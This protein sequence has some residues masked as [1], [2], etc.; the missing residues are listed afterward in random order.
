MESKR[1]KR[2]FES[3][4]PTQTTYDFA[5]EMFE[6]THVYFFDYIRKKDGSFDA[7][8]NKDDN[9][10]LIND[11]YDNAKKEFEKVKDSIQK[12][13]DKLK[14]E[15]NPSRNTLNKI[16]KN[17][18]RL[19]DLDFV[20]EQF[21]NPEKFEKFRSKH[22]QQL[23]EY[24]LTS[25]LT[26][27]K[28]EALKEAIRESNEYD[29]DGIVK[30]TSDTGESSTH[31]MAYN[32]S[33]LS[34]KFNAKQNAQKT[35]KLLIGSIP[36]MK[37]KDGKYKQVRSNR[38]FTPKTVSFGKTFNTLLTE[39]SGIKG[40]EQAIQKLQSLKKRFPSIEYLFSADGLNLDAITSKNHLSI[41]KGKFN[42][43]IQFAQTFA[44]TMNKYTVGLL[45]EGGER[46]FMDSNLQAE[47]K[48]ITLRWRNN[49]SAISLSKNPN[50]TIQKDNFYNTTLFAYK[51]IKNT[52]EAYEF[53]ESIGIEFTDK[54]RIQELGYVSV[55]KDVADYILKDIQKGNQL[56]VLSPKLGTNHGQNL[57]RLLDIEYE[58]NPDLVVTSHTGPDGQNIYNHTLNSFISNLL[59]NFNKFDNWNDLMSF[60]PH[61]NSETNAWL[62]GSLLLKKNG[63][64]F[65]KDGDK[66]P[67]TKLI[68]HTLESVSANEGANKVEFNKLSEADKI[69][70]VIDRTLRGY[71]DILRVADKSLERAFSIG[72]NNTTHLLDTTTW[73]EY[74]I[75]Y[76]IDDIAYIHEQK[77]NPVKWRYISENNENNKGIFINIIL[78]NSLNQ[79]N[80]D[81][82]LD[83]IKNGKDLNTLFKENSEYKK[84]LAHTFNNYLLKRSEELLSNLT[85]NEVVVQNGQTY[86][87]KGITLDKNKKIF[88]YQDIIFALREYVIADD[89]MNTEQLKLI[90]GHPNQYKNVDEFFKRAGGFPGTKKNTIDDYITATY[91]ENKLKRTDGAETLT[92][93]NAGAKISTVIPDVQRYKSVYRQIVFDDVSVYDDV[94]GKIG[95]EGD[96]YS[97][98]SLDMY[99]D[100][101]FRNN[102]WSFGEN[103]LED[104]Y[105]WEMQN[106]YGPKIGQKGFLTK[107]KFDELFNRDGWDGIV[108]DPE[109]G[110]EIT[111]KP[112]KKINMLKP[113]HVGPYAEK[114]SQLNMT[115]TSFGVLYP[116][117]FK[118][119]PNKE[120][121][122]NFMRGNK[123]SV[124]S[125]YSANK[126]ITTKLNSDGNL[127]KLYVPTKDNPEKY[128]LNLDNLK[129]GENAVYQDTYVENWGIQLDTGF[130]NK[131][132]VIYGTQMMKQIMSYVYRNGA[133]IP[134]LEHLAKLTEEYKSLNSQRLD[135]GK[136]ELL[137]ELD[138]KVKDGEY[139]IND[140]TKFKDKL[141]ELADARGMDDN[142]YD[143]INFVDKNLGIDILL[144]RNKFE[145]AI[146][147]LNNAMVIK[148][149]RTAGGAYYQQPATLWE[150][151]KNEDGSITGYRPY[152]IVKDE[153]GKVIHEG[154]MASDYLKMYEATKDEDGNI[155]SVGS[156]EVLLPN[157]FKN[158]PFNELDSMLNL[159]VAFR[160]PTQGL[161]SIEAIKVVGFLDESAGDTIVLPS[162]IVKKA[163]SN[164]QIDKLNVYLPYFFIDINGYAQYIYY[165]VPYEKYLTHVSGKILNP[166]EYKK[167]QI[168]NRILEIQ[169]E[170][171]LHPYNYANLTKSLDDTKKI[172]TDLANEIYTLKTG[173]IRG[174]GKVEDIINRVFLN[175]VSQ[176]FLMAQK[177]IGITALASPFHIL[178][179]K[180]NLAIDTS[181]ALTH[182]K[183]REG[184]VSLAGEMDANSKKMNR[185]NIAEMLRQWLS[186]ALDA[187][188]DNQMY[189]LNLNIETLNVALYLTMAGVPTKTMLYFL[190]QP[191]ILDY[192]ALK[193]SSRSLI[194]SVHKRANERYN[195]ITKRFYTVYLP[196]TL[197][198]KEV[199]DIINKKYGESKYIK[200]QNSDFDE[201]S[202]KGFIEIG[203][204]IP[205]SLSDLTL[206]RFKDEKKQED[207]IPY[208]R[209]QLFILEEYLKYKE[210]SNLINEAINAASWDTNSAGMCTAELLLRVHQAEKVLK[211]KK[212]INYNTLLKDPDGFIEPYFRH[213]KD[214]I[215]QFLPIFRTLLG[216]KEIKSIVEFML[217]RFDEEFGIP[218]DIKVKILNSIVPEWF[219]YNLV[220]YAMER[221][222]YQSDKAFNEAI[223]NDKN[224]IVKQINDLFTGE[225]S[226]AKKV[227]FLKQ[228]VKDFNAVLDGQLENTVTRSK[229][230]TIE[231][232]NVVV[233]NQEKYDMSIR[234]FNKLNEN[235]FLKALI[236]N[237]SNDPNY[238]DHVILEKKSRD[239]LEISTI[240]SGWIQLTEETD[241]VKEE[242]DI[243]EVGLGLIK[244]LIKQDGL[245]PSPS[246]F[247]HLTPA[248]LYTSLLKKALMQKFPF[249]SLT[250]QNAFKF[251]LEFH[252][253]NFKNKNI[254]PS[255]NDTFIKSDL[256]PFVKGRKKL[257]NPKMTKKEV[258]MLIRYGK[259]IFHHIP[260]IFCKYND[261][262]IN[263]Y[264]PNFYDN[265]TGGQRKNIYGEVN[266]QI[267]NSLSHIF[268]MLFPGYFGDTD[269]HFGDI[270]PLRF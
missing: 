75:E 219:T 90:F 84:W 227:E 102:D 173:E 78:E 267:M 113:Q 125:F 121:M 111:K 200:I 141:K 177:A 154:L 221:F 58:T 88:S 40:P 140:L 251:F 24:G 26:K 180:A 190:N 261:E 134:G 65:D 257:L 268:S 205:S 36:E 2:S 185:L 71:H 87:T 96:G 83:A 39:L 169:R 64:I 5:E 104:L 60:Y 189:V 155:T 19:Q 46:D 112:S 127:N 148:Q 116:S 153:K 238:F 107:E 47:R 160:I 156:M 124:V 184:Y 193:S 252:L 32:S 147:S 15:Q 11:A 123:I 247:I 211:S 166:R 150:N 170:I 228:M 68:L 149:K 3:D 27:D 248:K 1:E 98:I 12:V 256:Y 223:K 118:G 138:I 201:R 103:S 79:T 31:D 110:R 16:S 152:R 213:N 67:N 254:V 162:A 240:V 48:G 101:L 262:P 30:E 13:V 142:V 151:N 174:K 45:K 29:E 117:D 269:P 51:Q 176:R 242:G 215:D 196:E 62:K 50:K 97:L 82:L 34:I 61:L 130:K 167:L 179:Q 264:L 106:Y 92:D 43:L 191:I 182:N 86:V 52:N 109:T 57:N 226:I 259:T 258:N 131:D 23:M 192:I 246:N 28:K 235:N 224:N 91:I 135:I 81:L 115:K 202:L 199:L 76:L 4:N 217:K 69:A 7:L 195:P 49:A 232:N 186:E 175:K 133:V 18:L 241:Y 100:M 236:P 137:E 161:A 145:A 120:K 208:L 105:Q 63:L 222:I 178:A 74:Y 6:A 171:L 132:A 8:F 14:L 10:Q 55:I 157:R 188:K 187:S 128:E 94:F 207:Y 114:G 85:K 253:N 73:D 159:G 214:L 230:G 99:R 260:E 37:V 126:G 56:N 33:D 216:D 144:N 245:Q 136:E 218:K 209:S 194:K 119:Y 108:I 80:S 93:T 53:L 270:D 244:L 20:L 234:L 229:Y 158:I 129:F 54:D 163:G 263:K 165:N 212:L 9:S 197:S 122:F 41:P 204:H 168:E 89:V 66:R 220:T 243:K 255:I 95:E 35:I 250:V 164:F 70:E 203:K 181:I 265:S 249:E 38:L 231:V 198:E 25:K 239:L 172:I 72:N 233:F 17:E 210:D 42:E 59:D 44:K 146:Y 77:A 266:P 22:A 225:G 206:L 139:Y 143:S 237:I 21:N 183:T